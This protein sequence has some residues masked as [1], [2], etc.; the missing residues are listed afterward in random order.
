[1]FLPRVFKSASLRTSFLSR[2]DKQSASGIRA[3][4]A[5]K[6]ISASSDK[7]GLSAERERRDIVVVYKRIYEQIEILNVQGENR[8]FSVTNLF[9]MHTLHTGRA[10]LYIYILH[11]HTL[12]VT[13]FTCRARDAF[14][15]R[16][17][18]TT[19]RERER[20]ALVPCSV[21]GARWLSLR[22]YIYNM[23][24]YTCENGHRSL[25]R[26]PQMRG[27]HSVKSQ[28]HRVERATSKSFAAQVATRPP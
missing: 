27:Y 24:I 9:A 23:H 4:G 5:Y 25:A 21:H 8:N 18:P 10:S 14:T 2:W 22:V 1:M 20:D 15:P 26:A 3:R 11:T 28:Q 16:T 13:G 12:C 17:A 19:K 7:Q 6:A